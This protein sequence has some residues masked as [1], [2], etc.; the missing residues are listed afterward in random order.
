M[1]EETIRPQEIFDGFLRLSVEDIPKFFPD[2]DRVRLSCPACGGESEL[3]FTK[4]GFGYEECVGCRTLFVNPR[5]PAAA[6]FNYY[7]N[8][9]SCKY[10]ATTFYRATADARRQCLWK[11]KSRAVRDALKRLGCEDAAVIDIGGG[12]GI[13]AEEYNLL[14]GS[15]TVV[16]EPSADL[17]KVCRERN[18]DVIQDFLENVSPSQLPAGKK[19][20]VS[21]ELFEHL[22]EPA[23]FC[24]HLHR[25]MSPGDLFLFTTLSGTGLDIRVL[26]ENSKSVS[27]PHH[28]NFF[29]P[30]SVS[31]LLE[32]IGFRTLEI[33][34]P[35]SLDV[36][37]L[38]NNKNLIRDRFWKV[39][40]ETGSDGDFSSMQDLISK[41]GFSSH[42]M[43]ICTRV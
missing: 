12:Y 34:T 42:M 16:I 13:F 15:N 6:F 24:E 39:F 9:E 22:H 31:I 37:I 26:W 28:L 23:V 19:V 17:A 27:P 30:K 36:D 14:T 3:A 11:P 4:H 10:W 41:H 38:R 35:G 32:R 43:T 2:G 5:P 29:N 18:L 33:T 25:L 8:S 7:R 20:F 1:K 40:V 21:F